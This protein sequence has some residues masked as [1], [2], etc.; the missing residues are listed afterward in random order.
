MISSTRKLFE[1][2]IDGLVRNFLCV[3]LYIVTIQG[4]GSGTER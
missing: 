2:Q 4:T 3:F 1:A